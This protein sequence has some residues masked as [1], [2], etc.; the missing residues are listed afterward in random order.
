MTRLFLFILNILI[1][2]SCSTITKPNTNY[3]KTGVLKDRYTTLYYN[4][5]EAGK[6]LEIDHH[7]SINT[8]IGVQDIGDTELFQ[9][10]KLN[11]YWEVNYQLTF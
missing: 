11:T 7:N 8:Y 1:I 6:S 4:Y 5:V 3:I 2:T 9:S 10:N